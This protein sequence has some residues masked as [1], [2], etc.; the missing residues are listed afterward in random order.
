LCRRFGISRKNG[1]KWFS[2]YRFE[3]AFQHCRS[4]SSN[5]GTLR[6]FEHM[7]NDLAKPLL[8]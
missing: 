2:G 4:C 3:L 5:F 8:K 6:T 1:Y 7:V